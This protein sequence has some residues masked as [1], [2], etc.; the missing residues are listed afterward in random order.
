MISKKT[1]FNLE[2]PTDF[3][4]ENLAWGTDAC[5]IG[6]FLPA[7]GRWMFAHD[8]LL[9]VAPRSFLEV[10]RA[11]FEWKNPLEFY[12]A[13]LD[14][15]WLAEHPG[16]FVDNATQSA[17]D[18]AHRWDEYCWRKFEVEIPELAHIMS[19]A[20]FVLLIEHTSAI[21]ARAVAANPAEQGLGEA[22]V[23]KLLSSK[24]MK[25][26]SNPGAE[27]L[28]AWIAAPVQVL[29]E[30]LEGKPCCVMENFVATWKEAI[31]AQIGA[32]NSRQRIR[33]PD[34]LRSLTVAGLQRFFGM[35]SDEY[36]LQLEL[37]PPQYWAGNR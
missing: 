14:R 17:E 26:C 29:P 21:D 16:R 20:S 19:S 13:N 6:P 8:C 28:D 22:V 24:Y 27:S 36:R 25:V 32:G 11:L 30:S 3:L 33:L 9:P 15:E 10:M 2:F 1:E 35:K 31:E 12:A 4:R 18:I 37:P 23:P 7:P 34:G 5:A